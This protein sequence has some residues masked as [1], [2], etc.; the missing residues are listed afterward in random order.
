MMDFIKELLSGQLTSDGYHQYQ[1]FIIYQIR[2]YRW[3]V[4]IVKERQTSLFETTWDSE[5]YSSFSHQFM[6]FLIE[7]NKISIFENIPKGGRFAYLSLIMAQYVADQ[8]R[9]YQNRFGI[10][11]S[12]VKRSALKTLNSAPNVFVSQ[13]IDKKTFW[14]LV[15]VENNPLMTNEKM[16]SEIHF[17]PPIYLDIQKLTDQIKIRIHIQ[18]EERLK[19]I[20][21]IVNAPVEEAFLIKEVWNAFPKVSTET[22]FTIEALPDIESGKIEDEIQTDHEVSIS[23]IM[24]KMDDMD[25]Q[26]LSHYFFRQTEINLT[27]ASKD[28][29]IPKSTLYYRL[30]NINNTIRSHFTPHSEADALIFLEKFQTIL[31][32]N[33]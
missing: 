30:K 26:I 16:R 18:V 14:A 22:I 24:T 11:Y 1:R 25:K 23:A 31:N 8:I 4:Y 2:K 28:L 20:L 13:I 12:K 17:L 7:K 10:S 29:L 19:D 33:H 21:H 3:P 15:G 32:N 6:V 9:I 27:Q 5:A